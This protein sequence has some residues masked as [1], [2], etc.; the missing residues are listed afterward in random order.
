M[1]QTA[2]LAG[3]SI[4]S[5]VFP[6]SLPFLLFEEC[7]KKKGRKIKM[8]CLFP[9]LLTNFIV[10]AIRGRASGYASL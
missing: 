8:A 5:K 3:L 9:F 2:S 1:G 10:V 7:D 6:L 4:H